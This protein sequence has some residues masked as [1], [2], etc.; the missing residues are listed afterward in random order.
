M[1]WDVTSSPPAL[2]KSLPHSHRDWITGCVWTPDCVVSP[3][4]ISSLILT[5]LSYRSPIQSCYLRDFYYHITI[6]QHLS[7]FQISSSN[8]GRLCLWDLQ[9]GQCLRE[10][11]WKS[12]LTSVCC[13]VRTLYGC[14][15]ENININLVFFP[16]RKL[17]CSQLT[18]Q[19]SKS[20]ID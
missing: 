14:L 19:W 3:H 10:I 6:H 7:V 13:V 18:Y 11:S 1:L 12:P 9:A 8:D 2:S 4:Y 16:P 5:N 20:F 15:S 17:F